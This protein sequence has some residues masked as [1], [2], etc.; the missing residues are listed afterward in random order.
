MQ[1]NARGKAARKQKAGESQARSEAAGGSFRALFD[2]SPVPM[3]VYDR[4]SLRILAA[5]ESAVAQYGYTSEQLLAMSLEGLQPP[6]DRSAVRAEALKPA[7]DG[8]AS[9]EPA[10]PPG[11]HR[12]GI[13]P[14]LCANG[15]VLFDE[16]FCHEV[17]FDGHDAA[18]VSYVDVTDKLVAERRL[19]ETAESLQRSKVHLARAQRIAHTS[20]ATCAP[21][22]LHGRMK[23]MASSA[24]RPGRPRRHATKFWTASTP[25]T[26]PPTP[27]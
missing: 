1:D 25:T 14:H 16:V 23:P 12:V 26:A 19:H 6:E 5:N 9:P 24:S 18:I 22:S 7:A 13:R 21:A 11:L 17:E 2:C 27:P 15:S 10:R 20:S 4:E 3:L 8:G